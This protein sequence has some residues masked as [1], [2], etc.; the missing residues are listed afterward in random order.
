MHTQP[1]D[2]IEV[3]TKEDHFKGILMPSKEDTLILKLKS[4]Y[5]IG[6]SKSKIRQIKLIREKTTKKETKKP[7]QKKKGL[8]NI[9]ILHTGGTISSK[10]D[11]ETGAVS[12]KFTPEEILGMYPKLKEIVNIDSKLISNIFSEDMR[13]AHY[14]LIAKAISLEIEKGSNGIIITH[15]TDTMHYTSAALSFILEDLP[16]PVILVGAQR[17]SDRGSSDGGMNLEAACN[18]IA[19]TD[20][21]EVAI[22]MHETTEDTSCVILPGL[23]SRKMHSSRRDAFKAINNAPL[24]RILGSKVQV[25]KPLKKP[26][27]KLILKPIKEGLKIGILKVHPNLMAEELRTYNKFDGLIIEGTG[28]AGNLGINTFDKTTEYNKKILNELKR[29]TSKMPVVAT[30]QTIYGRVNMNV[31]STGRILQEIGVIGNLLDMTP[32]TAFIKLAWVLSNYEDV[33]EKFHENLR[34]EINPRILE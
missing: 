6:I 11:Y 4:G 31:Y 15:G 22:C 5:N 10:I 24:A 9:T 13:F 7:I 3:L 26:G 2:Q 19:K 27:K 12:S 25:L 1:G 23:K 16:I 21:S 33:K 17:S 32:E 29:L 18:F 34:G 8:K 30:T 14:N 28:I 20:F